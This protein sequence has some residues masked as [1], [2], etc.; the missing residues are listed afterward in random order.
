MRDAWHDEGFARRW[1]SEDALRTN[2]DREAQ[3]A[4]L[5]ALVA[6][7]WRDGDRLLDLGVGSGLVEDALFERLPDIEVVGIDRSEAMLAQARARHRGRT[8]LRL[9]GGGFE[10][11]DSL[12]SLDSLGAEGSLAPPFEFVI[13]VQAL[14]EVADHVKRAV[15]GFVRRRIA[16]SGLFLV[17][18]RFDYEPFA[19]APEYRCLWNRLNHGAPGERA[20]NGQPAEGQPIEEQS[21]E[22]HPPETPLS[23]EDY[24]ARY[25]AKTD[26]VGTVEDYL[27]WMREAGFDAACL[28]QQFNRALI[29]ARPR[30]G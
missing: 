21:A 20:A 23:F 13:C 16:P 18:D 25:A 5:V 27:R 26:H 17:L 19:L 7:S 28:Y 1:D 4:L 2:P 3:I 8:N 15:F 10:D 9:L 22:R 12:D 14:H 29:A 11:L 6:E 30:A 24:R